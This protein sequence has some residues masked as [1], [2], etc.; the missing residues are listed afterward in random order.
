M[1]VLIVY[2]SYYGN[3]EQVAQG[4]A[5]A[6][7]PAAQVEVMRAQDAPGGL[8]GVDLLIV[9]A[10][11]RMFRPAGG[12]TGFLRGL[13]AGRLKGIKV[14]AFDTRI[15]ACDTNSRLLRAMVKAFGYAAEKIAESLRKKGGVEVASPAGFLVKDTEGPLKDGEL[16]RA[17]EWARGMLAQQ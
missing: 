2:D 4:I 16:D 12:V 9:G 5:H 7:A 3:T 6:L 13:A 15:A 17:A 14:A 8:S 10:P 1:K 11:T